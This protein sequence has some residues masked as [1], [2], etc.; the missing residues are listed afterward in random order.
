MT[1]DETGT[2]DA[3]RSFAFVADD[4]F[5]RVLGLE[6]RVVEVFGFL[7]HVLTK[8]AVVKSGSGDRA[9][10]MEAAR[11]HALREL[12]RMTC[13]LDVGDTLIFGAGFE[14]VDRGE[15]KEMLNFPLELLELAVVDAESLFIEVTDDR[16]H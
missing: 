12:H 7:E 10:M 16:D 15:V 14:V 4:T 6:V 11:L 9:D 1:H 13:A 5:G 3:K 8:Y 2:I